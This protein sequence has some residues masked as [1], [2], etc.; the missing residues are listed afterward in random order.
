[1]GV[2]LALLA[3]A[4]QGEDWPTFLGPRHDGTSRETGLLATWP[5]KGPPVLWKLE[6]GQT[7]AAPSVVKDALVLFH[8][9]KDEEIVERINPATGE[10]KWRCAYATAYDD[11]FGYANGPRSA[12]TIDEGRIYTLGAEGRLHALDL[13]TGKALWS[14]A[15]HPEYFGEAKQNFFGVAGSPRVDGD[16]ILLNLGDE[17]EGC[18]TAID[19]KSG[20]TIWRVNGDGASFGTAAC[21]TV[22]KSR[23]AFFLT[24]EGGLGVGAADGKV[25]WRRPFRARENFSA[26]AAS[27]VVLGDR[28]FLSSSYGVGSA[29]FKLE[30][31][32]VKELWSNQALG[33]HWFTPIHHDGHLYGFEGRHENEAELR[34]V[35]LSDGE[36]MWSRGGYGRGSMIRADGKFILISEDGRL[37]L[38]DISPKGLREISSVQLLARH[39]WWAPVLSR[40]LLYVGNFDHRAGKAALVCLDLRA[41]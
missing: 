6:L 14:R 2:V 27:P 26:N 8:R 32:G 10:K 12:P 3:V 30:E 38:A 36:V 41:K 11:R 4:L 28:L 35:R 31:G 34:C 19:K 16:A 15:L 18:V 13:E 37:V 5:E 7:Y 20:K 17:R 9:V 40:G 21:A 29:L 1:M 24:R 25:Y 23:I 22:G 39:C 33:A